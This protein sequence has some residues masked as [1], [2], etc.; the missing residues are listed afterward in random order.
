MRG[1]IV[2]LVV[3]LALLAVFTMQNPEVVTVR[4]LA[5]TGNT[6]L[7][8]VVLAAFSAGV[9]GAGLAALPGYFRKR[10]EARAANQKI[11]DLEAEAKALREEIYQL[12]KKLEAPRELPKPGGTD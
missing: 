5:F 6:L 10:A 4:F 1:S 3:L 8:V 7:L 9:F 2:L 11:H 12:R